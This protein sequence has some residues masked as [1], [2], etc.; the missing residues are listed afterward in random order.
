MV[1][2]FFNYKERVVNEEIKLMR[3]LVGKEG[4]PL[5]DDWG[6]FKDPDETMFI[7]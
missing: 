2:V 5:Y 4:F 6:R 3:K 1:K 7:A